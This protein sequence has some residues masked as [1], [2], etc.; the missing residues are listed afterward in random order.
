MPSQVELLYRQYK[1]KKEKLQKQTKEQVIEKYGQLAEKVP[2]DVKGLQQS[3]QYV[4]YDRFGRVI[5]GQVT[6]TRSR[7]VWMDLLSLDIGNGDTVF[8]RLT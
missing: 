8:Q 5:V 4:E 6:K 2:E 7:Y 1:D 3:E